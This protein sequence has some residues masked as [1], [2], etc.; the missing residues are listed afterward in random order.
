[1]ASVVQTHVAPRIG[2]GTGLR[3]PNGI[4]RSILNAI[5]IG[6]KKSSATAM[7]AIGTNASLKCATLS[8]GLGR[9][10]LAGTRGT[11]I[12]NTGDECWSR[13]GYQPKD[14]AISTERNVERH[15][16]RLVLIRG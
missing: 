13:C 6:A 15:G 11:L 4:E 9:M 5:L 3:T 2:A 1:M 10:R 8:A 16:S 12:R 14:T 7:R